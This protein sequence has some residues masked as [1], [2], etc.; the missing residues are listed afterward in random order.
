MIMGSDGSETSETERARSGRF[1]ILSLNQAW[2]LG[3]GPGPTVW[4]Q[5]MVNGHAREA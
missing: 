2:K 5:G 1:W 3:L 4:S